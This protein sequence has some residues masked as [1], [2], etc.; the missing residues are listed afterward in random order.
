MPRIIT[1]ERELALKVVL[2]IM[3]RCYAIVSRTDRTSIDEER[4]KFFSMQ[5]QDREQNDL[6]IST[7]LEFRKQV[8][9]FATSR[10]RFRDGKRLSFSLSVE[11]SCTMQRVARWTQVAKV[12]INS[13]LF[14]RLS[15]EGI[16]TILD[17]IVSHQKIQPHLRASKRAIALFMRDY[18][19]S[20]LGVRDGARVACF[21]KAPRRMSLTMRCWGGLILR[22]ITFSS[23]IIIYD[24]VG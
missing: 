11:K 23:G 15:K 10:S 16:A 2:Q 3:P 14:H 18:T 5:Q 1:N 20:R 7:K 12:L 17:G 22:F 21:H 19:Y 8:F 6:T 4:R 13:P 24:H 9:T